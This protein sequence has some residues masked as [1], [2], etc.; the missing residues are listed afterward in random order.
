MKNENSGATSQLSQ[1]YLENDCQN[2]VCV[3]LVFTRLALP[4]ES[5]FCRACYVMTVIRLHSYH[6]YHYVCIFLNF[7]TWL[8][9]F[10]S[11]C[12][13][14]LYDSADG[15]LNFQIFL[16]CLQLMAECLSVIPATFIRKIMY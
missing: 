6:H 7:M 14:Y 1:V 15:C 8:A 11:V 13:I 5:S 16:L 3:C 2:G 12:L 4:N 9:V 10:C